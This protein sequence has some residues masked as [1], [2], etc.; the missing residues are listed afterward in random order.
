M[1]DVSRTQEGRNVLKAGRQSLIQNSPLAFFCLFEAMSLAIWWTPLRSTFLLALQ[2]EQ[3][4]H[5]LLIFPVSL[6]LIFLDWKSQ[7]APVSPGFTP[8]SLMVIA[9]PL[10]IISP[11]LFSSPDIDLSAEMLTFVLWTIAAFTLCFG[12]RAFQRAMFPLL[13]L[14]WI[15]PLPGFV[16]N[17]IVRLLQQGSAAAAHWIFLAARVPVEQRGL[18]LRIPGFI[19]EVAPECSSIRSS[20][21]LIVTTMVLAYLLLRSQWRRVLLVAIAIPLSVVKNG[22]RI[23]VLGFLAVRVDPSFLTGRLHHEG[24][25]I[26]LLIALAIIF[27]F[28]WILRKGEKRETRKGQ[29]GNRISV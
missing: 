17:T 16:V 20:M 14:L 29:T 11:R 10:R 28:I 26:Y 23:F 5:I 13:F 15:V 25:V 7:A 2:D 19:L 22:L 12:W 18:F 3:Y 24:G 21:T 27:V 1:A 4:S 8:A 9:I 6:A